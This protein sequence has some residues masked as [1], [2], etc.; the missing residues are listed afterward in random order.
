MPT[1]PWSFFGVPRVIV[2]DAAPLQNDHRH[3]GIGNYV[4]GLLKALAERG[5]NGWA[6]LLVAGRPRPPFLARQRG[7]SL[8]APR[9]LEYHGGW[10]VGELAIPVMARA[11]RWEAFH[12][13]DPR[14]VPEPRLVRT[15]ATIYDLTPLDDPGTWHGLTFDQQIAYRRALSNARRADAIVTISQ[16]VATAIAER[17][18]LSPTRI[19]VVSPGI[20]VAEWAVQGPEQER[21]GLL[22]VGA[23]A[24]HKN[25]ALVLEA[26]STLPAARRPSLTIIGPWST[27]AISDLARLATELGCPMP[28]VEAY[29]SADRL[30]DLYRTSSALVMPSRMEGFGLPVLEAMASGCRVI[31]SDIPVHREISSGIATLVELDRRDDL[32]AAIDSLAGEPEIL[33][34]ERAAAGRARAAEYSWDHSVEA[35]AKAYRSIGVSL[36]LNPEPPAE[37]AA[38]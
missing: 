32:S 35:L 30:R 28:M 5:T 31:A 10:L 3:R 17:L 22:F 24:P 34:A 15:V 36:A 12:A 1:R 26:L 11:G 38:T 7:P 37:R 20:N 25:L 13:T 6:P 33:I 23:P 18:K 4:G 19:H 14:L 21:A 27:D 16:S 2:I 29:A 8:W 9:R